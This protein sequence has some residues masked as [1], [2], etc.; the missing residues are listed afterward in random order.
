M[1]T[2]R[3]GTPPLWAFEIIGSNVTFVTDTPGR[4]ARR[5]QAGPVRLAFRVWSDAPAP[6]G[7]IAP[8]RP[9]SPSAVLLHA[10][11]EDAAKWE[12]LA[13]KLAPSWRV[14][15]PDLRGHGDSE[16]SGPYTVDQLTA[17][18]EAFLDALGL[19]RVLLGGHSVG[20]V[21]AYL[22]AARCPDRV[23]HLILEEPVPPF[24]RKAFDLS[25]LPGER[26]DGIS[27][28]PDAI[29]LSA[30]FTD[31]PAAWREALGEIKAP[32]LLIAG[33]PDSHLDQEQLAEMAGLISDCQHVTIPAG[34]W[35]HADA[36]EEFATAVAAFL[37]R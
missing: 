10:P 23:T 32:T 8:G 1:I 30:E 17:D 3:T 28:D 13:E 33:G 34:H 31:P 4:P 7:T 12:P 18:L 5:I 19:R 20:A 24:P 22:F 16:Q 29:A 26:P 6:D 11:G 15:A 35:V 37:N 9:P 27:Y 25:Q 36:P 2:Q 14:H 21:P